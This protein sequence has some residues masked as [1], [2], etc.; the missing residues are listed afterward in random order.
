MTIAPG[1]PIEAD[2]I[3]DLVDLPGCRAYASAAVSATV[4]GT[5]TLVPMGG[6]SYDDTGSMHSTSSNT[7]RIVIPST[8]RYH[9]VAQAS[10]A[11]NAT[12]RR[13][14]TVRLNAAGSNSG[15]T[16]IMLTS[17]QASASSGTTIQATDE[18]NFN[19]GDYI[20]MFTV[21]VS[22]GPLNVDLGEFITFMAV[23]KLP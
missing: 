8:G 3:T 13:A 1:A 7:S 17:V 15:G 16:Q 4:S 10:F 12:S 20:E 22:G 23:R 5:L 6:E 9:V 2:D 19:A 11:A 14:V 18:I 21:Q